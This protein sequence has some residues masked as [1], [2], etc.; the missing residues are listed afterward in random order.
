M[1][2][3]DTNWLSKLS[4]GKRDRSGYFELIIESEYFWSSTENEDDFS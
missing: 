1:N 3:G 4:V 2:F